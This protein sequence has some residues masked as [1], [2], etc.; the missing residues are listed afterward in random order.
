MANILGHCPFLDKQIFGLIEDKYI[1]GPV[2]QMLFAHYPARDRSDFG[3]I[4]INNLDDFVFWVI[5]G[6][7]V[8]RKFVQGFAVV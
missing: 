2:Y 1:A 5:H 3:I 8:P 4:F 7:T 6:V